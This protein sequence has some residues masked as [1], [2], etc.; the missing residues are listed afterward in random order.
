M[1][2]TLPFL[3]Y[4]R[5]VFVSDRPLTVGFGAR[6]LADLQAG[7]AVAQGELAPGRLGDRRH[8]PLA[9]ACDCD[10]VA[11]AITLSDE[12]PVPIEGPNGLVLER[13]DPSAATEGDDRALHGGIR[14]VPETPIDLPR[15]RIAH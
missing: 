4:V 1:V 11:V 15:E 7:P 3:S 2:R 8:A 10:L 14:R 13:Q 12:S 5:V 9:I 6:R